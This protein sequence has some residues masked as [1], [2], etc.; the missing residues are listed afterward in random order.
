M[1][2]DKRILFVAA[3]ATV[4][5]VLVFL[6]FYWVSTLPSPTD[7]SLSISIKHMINF[8]TF[9]L[10]WGAVFVYGLIIALLWPRKRK[11]GTPFSREKPCAEIL[12][13]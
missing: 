7:V 12:P 2:R 9:S 1:L 3:L 13:K 6:C 4:I 8:K 10:I 5:S 11:R